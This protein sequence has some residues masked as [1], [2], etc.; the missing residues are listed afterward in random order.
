L[1]H[2][3]KHLFL[4]RPHETQI[5]QPGRNPH[6]SLRIPI[7]RDACPRCNRGGNLNTMRSSFGYELPKI[8]CLFKRLMTADGL[9]GNPG[10]CSGMPGWRWRANIFKTMH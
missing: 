7:Y 5:L 8:E 2:S 6:L 9:A 4:V 1:P 10:A 3:I